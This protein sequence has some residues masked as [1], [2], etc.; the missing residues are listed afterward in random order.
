MKAQKRIARSE[1]W[2]RNGQQTLLLSASAINSFQTCHK[3]YEYEKKRHL[4]PIET[5]NSLN[6]GTVTHRGLESIFR[7]IGLGETDKDKAKQR[8]LE[9]I[10][11]AAVACDLPGEDL[12]KIQALMDCYID[13]YFDEDASLYDVVGVEVPFTCYPENPRT[14]RSDLRFGTRGYIDAIVKNRITD[15]YWVI[16]H[17][18]AGIVSD[19]YMQRVN[20]D[21]QSAIYIEAVRQKCGSCAGVI[22][23]VLRKPKHEISKGETDEEFEAR[24][25]ASK[26]GRVKRKYPESLTE[27]YNRIRLGMD[28]SYLIRQMVTP[29]EEMMR[30]FR[31]EFFATA[32]EIN[33]TKVYAKSTC[34]CL[35]YGKCP[36]MDL[37]CNGGDLSGL[38]DRYSNT[39]SPYS[40]E[41]DHD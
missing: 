28:E 33:R 31:R 39:N 29:N 2:R 41:D 11:D 19:G 32:R 15:E 18:T 36:Y 6:F 20:I 21:W 38:E 27:F 17:K 3:M 30:Q 25:A 24:K 12:S 37:C 23:D 14:G 34:N 8:A 9:E 1:L 10:I 5:S 40:A 4:K 13:T 7:W 35:K 26:T 16:E 22:Y